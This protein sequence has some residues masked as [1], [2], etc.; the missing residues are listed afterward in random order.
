MKHK[1][2]AAS[3]VFS[4]L[5]LSACGLKTE[6]KDKVLEKAETV[7]QKVDQKIQDE[8]S[9]TDDELLKSLNSETDPNLDAEFSKLD[10]ELQ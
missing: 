5:F 8:K 9:E 6:V 2:I 3:F 1:L 10:S 7:I 4:S